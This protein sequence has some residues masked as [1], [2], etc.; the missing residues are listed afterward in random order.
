MTTVEALIE[1]HEG[2]KLKPY[3]DTVGKLTIGIGRNLDDVGITV[4]EA[5][6]LQAS[7]IAACRLDLQSLFGTTWW[8]IGDVR[9][10]AL[11]D[12]RFELGHAGFREFAHMIAA[13]QA[14]DWGAAADAALDSKWAKQ[15][16]SRA[17]TDARMLRTG[18][19]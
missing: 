10:A 17:E 18:E 8:A 12:M 15:V 5:R 1:Q 14:G 11:I 3:R 4:A 7:D 19:W 13:V 9:Q 6:I 2:L 16:P